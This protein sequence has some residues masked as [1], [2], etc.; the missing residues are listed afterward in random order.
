MD[1]TINK[2][3]SELHNKIYNIRKL[4]KF[5]NFKT[6][7]QFL[8]GFVFGK[9][10]YMVPLYSLTTE[11]NLNKLHKVI[12]TAARAAIGNYCY[13]KSINYILNKCKWF[14]IKDIIMISSL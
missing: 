10:H 6:R 13:K 2:L 5:T 14:D 1:K 3:S 12:M 4:T 7:Y 9:L 11:A 8:N